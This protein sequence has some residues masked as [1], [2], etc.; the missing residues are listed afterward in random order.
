M[1]ESIDVFRYSDL[2]AEYK[3]LQEKNNGLVE[4]VN[5]YNQKLNRLKN[6]PNFLKPYFENNDAANAWL[7]LEDVCKLTGKFWESE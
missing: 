5:I 4:L 1:M 2:L 6:A 7:A 3:L